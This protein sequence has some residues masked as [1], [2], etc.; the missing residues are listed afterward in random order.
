MKLGWKRQQAH[1][2]GQII[3]FFS[4]GHQFF[5]R[6]P[7]PPMGSLS[8]DAEPLL[9]IRSPYRWGGLRLREWCERKIGPGKNCLWHF[10]KKNLYFP[11][12]RMENLG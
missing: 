11:A 6:G 3:D 1:W 10:H 2:Q 9:L 7:P 12:W 4:S 5:D 8:D